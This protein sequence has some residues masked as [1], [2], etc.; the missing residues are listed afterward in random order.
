MAQFPTVI[1]KV[2]NH[3]GMTGRMVAKCDQPQFLGNSQRIASKTGAVM[4]NASIL[5][6]ARFT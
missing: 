2:F 1:D 3:G 5:R 6:A 4:I